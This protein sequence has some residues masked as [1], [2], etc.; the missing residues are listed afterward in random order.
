V[1]NDLG[2]ERMRGMH[3]HFSHQEYTEKGE[4]KHL[5]FEDTIYGPFFEPLSKE[6]VKRGMYPVIV[7]ESRDLMA[8]DAA[9][10][11][12]IYERDIAEA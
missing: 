11:K 12:E 7:C 5:T 3:V 1:E 4:R 6:I 9:K 2:S 8:E 10:M